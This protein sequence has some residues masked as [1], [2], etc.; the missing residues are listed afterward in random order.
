MRIWL[1]VILLLVQAVPA[2]AAGLMDC[3]LVKAECG[4]DLVGKRLWIVVPK[5][6][7]NTVTLCPTPPPHKYSE[8][9]EVRTGAFTVKGTI[10]APNYGTEFVVTLNDGKIAYVSTSAAIFLSE[11]DP[12]EDA[13]KQAAREQEQREECERR[14]QPKVGMTVQEATATCWGK[15]RKIAKTTTA[16][17]VQQDFLYGQGRIL[18]FDGDRLT[19]ILETSDR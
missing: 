8:C 11:T 5:S 1:W 9:R 2:S 19:V 4:R 13:R 10:P 12:V 7:P 17:G 16:A 18:R 3:V 14:G 15:P 6:N